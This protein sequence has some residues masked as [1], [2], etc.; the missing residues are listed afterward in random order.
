MGRNVENLS[1]WV[2]E[3]QRHRLACTSMQSDQ[4]LCYSPIGH[5]GSEDRA[6]DFK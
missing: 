6:D 5:I 3:H 4:R 1:S 2:C